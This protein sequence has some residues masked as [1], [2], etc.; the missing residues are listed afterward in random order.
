MSSNTY[1]Q[2][3]LTRHQVYLGRYA[4]G[5][6]NDLAEFLD[7]FAA[8]V[9]GGLESG[10]SIRRIRQALEVPD[11]SPIVDSSVEELTAHELRYM[12]ALLGAA[13]IESAPLIISAIETAYA[14]VT[15]A[16]MVL[17][18]TTGV[19]TRLTI[20]EMVGKLS[21][22]LKADALSVIRTGIAEGDSVETI[23]RAV[24]KKLNKTSRKHINSTVRT[25]TNHVGVQAREVATVANRDILSGERFFA[26]LDRHTTFLCY[27][28]DGKVFPVGQGPRPALHY[29]CR[30]GRAAVV[31]PEFMLSGLEGERPIRSAEGPGTTSGR[32]TASGFLRSQPAWFQEDALGPV[33][34]KLFREGKI[35][36]DKFVDRKG[37][38]VRIDELRDKDGKLLIGGR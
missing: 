20:D 24:S 35:T 18:S 13:T 22:S 30:S 11:M 9:A 14:T 8:Q 6:S 27:S 10:G 16:P 17:T 21:D 34:A 36:L 3:A 23:S 25:I 32:V 15:A 31:K 29:R 19:V 12:E 7:E 33:R 1:L 26:T 28:Y 4:T 38:V 37:A 5:V 2:E